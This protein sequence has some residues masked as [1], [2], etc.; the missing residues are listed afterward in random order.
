MAVGAVSRHRCSAT[1]SRAGCGRMPPPRSGSGRSRARAE[2]RGEPAIDL[3]HDALADEHRAVA[4][5]AAAPRRPDRAR[6]S[7]SADLAG[8]ELA[9]G[10]SPVLAPPAS[11]ARTATPSVSSRCAS[12]IA[13]TRPRA[14]AWRAYRAQ[15]PSSRVLLAAPGVPKRQ[16]VALARRPGSDIDEGQEVMGPCHS[17]ARASSVMA[18]RPMALSLPPNQRC[19]AR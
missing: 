3:E 2:R 14:D 17:K 16:E 4:L 5:L 18:S 10:R 19:A 13:P 8:A 12:K 9:A 1:P 6:A 7:R 15:R 11:M